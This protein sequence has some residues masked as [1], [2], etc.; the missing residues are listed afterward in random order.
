MTELRGQVAVVTGGG[1]GIGSAICRRLAAA[2]AEVVITY[3][4]DQSKARAAANAL[5]GGNHLILRVPVDDAEAQAKLASAVA[6]KYGRLDI[7]VNNAGVTKAVPHANLQDLD[8][9]TVDQI[10]RVNWRGAF[11]SIRALQPLLSA[12]AG[13]VVINISSI[14]G[15]TGVG[16]NVAYCASK[17]AMDSMTRSL[18]RALAPQ[19]RVL[20]VS[21][22][23]VNGE[24]AQ[25]MP[26]ALIAEQEDKTPLGRIADA[27]DVAE[28]VYAA[29][30]HLRFS[31]GDIIPVDGG[32][33]LG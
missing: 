12:G 25:R 28:A 8:D 27:E 29:V 10:F 2:G 24:Y 6:E 17:A 5:A 30:A 16:S 11:A 18:A 9:E 21:P 22:G 7:L 19:I 26:I 31:T 14:A 4:S 33:P 1:G 20:S 32:R 13:G 23:W 15:R 3:N